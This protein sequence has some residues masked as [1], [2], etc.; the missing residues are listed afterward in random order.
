MNCAIILAAGKGTRLKEEIGDKSLA[1]QFFI[2]K[3]RPLWWHSAQAFNKCTNLE[4]LV[5]VFNEEDIDFAKAQVEEF[6]NEFSI[7]IKI[8]LG[9][10][11]RQDS[12]RNGLQ[13]LPKNCKYIA[14]HDS[15]RAFVSTSLIAKSFEFITKNTQFKGVIPV[16]DLS[17]TIKLIDKDSISKTL[18]RNALKA[19]Q[20]P[21]V[22]DKESIVSAHTKLENS[23]KEFTDDASMLE[24]FDEKVGFI[25]GEKSNI[26]ITYAK[27]LE[28]LQDKKNIEF[29]STYGYDVH[30]YI[31]AKEKKA[32][33]FILGT[34]PIQTPICIKAH[35]DGDTLIHSL[36][37]A[38]LS[39]I[40][41]GDIGQHFPD[42]DNKYE[43][44]S[45]AILLD[46]ILDLLKE[47]PIQI[48]HV[49]ITIIAQEPKIAPY[50]KSIQK[51]IAQL[52]SLSTEKVNIKATTEEKLGFT[53]QV[54]GIKVVSLVSTKRE[55]I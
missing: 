34:V 52:L 42:N 28:L 4:S 10:K 41:A 53:G 50:T 2:Y 25:A 36:I 24:Y 5:F 6:K 20:T 40:G 51:A 3:D 30:A 35:S 1:K 27:D 23:D 39:L 8:T 49:D 19:V 16:L 18:D 11:R 47:K 12:V 33:P 7:P 54:Q 9:G 43:N 26:K 37:D 31:D 44:I 14:I 32:R 22:F 15:A 13:A 38:I 46:K 29:I 17:D 21:Q 55:C 48:I 45:S